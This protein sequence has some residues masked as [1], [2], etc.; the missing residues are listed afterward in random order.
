MK[1]Q[2][3]GPCNTNFD[4]GG[5]K[6]IKPMLFCAPLPLSWLW[7]CHGKHADTLHD[8]EATAASDTQQK[9]IKQD[10]T[11][12]PKVFCSA[13][14]ELLYSPAITQKG[15]LPGHAS[16]TAMAREPVHCANSRS[17]AIHKLQQTMADVWRTDSYGQ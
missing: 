17:Y 8:H 13:I 1:R 3:M 5:A 9:R 11:S 2:H 16:N 7:I 14:C 10:S 12:W 6:C 4:T 15:T